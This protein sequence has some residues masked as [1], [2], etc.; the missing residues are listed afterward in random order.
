MSDIQ[1][2]IETQKPIQV[3]KVS[4]LSDYISYKNNSENVLSDTYAY[5]MVACPHNTDT[6]IPHNFKISIDELI[7]IAYTFILPTINDKFNELLAYITVLHGDVP[8]ISENW[9]YVVPY[10]KQYWNKNW[11]DEN[12]YKVTLPDV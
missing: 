8:D 4:Q 2:T 6:S 11:V 5:I 1:K 7:K 3:R 12:D 10:I 9:S